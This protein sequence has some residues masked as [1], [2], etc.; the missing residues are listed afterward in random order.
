V[1][2]IETRLDPLVVAICALTYA[3]PQGLARLLAGI[4]GL[5]VPD[6]VAL[7][8]VIVDNNPDRSA[9]GACTGSRPRIAGELRYV[10][11]PVRG[12]ARGRNAALAAVRGRAHWI[13]FLDDDEV[14]QTDWLER[15]L[16]AQETHGADVV[17]GP[18]LPRF[19]APPPAWIVEGRFFEAE[20]HPS[21]TAMTRAYTNNVMFRASIPERLGIAFDER[22]NLRLGED[23]RFFET[24]HRAG[25]RIVW[26]D[27]AVVHE[28]IPPERT[29]ARWLVRRSRRYGDA[30]SLVRLADSGGFAAR[31]GL[32]L[33]GGL[34]IARGVVQLVPGALLGR[35]GVVASL[36][37]VAYGWGMLC[38]LCGRPFLEYGPGHERSGG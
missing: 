32:A 22:L 11:E 37:R 9:E 31:A 38:G 21:G 20:R 13:A 7:V 26:S 6:R 24:A 10:H 8:V 34:R 12:A 23:Q 18:A 30:T 3:R 33:E 5:H 2:G 19:E 1:A 14:P 35:R 16:A 27:E 36:R 29:T 28:W 15:L 17:T 25:S 4:E